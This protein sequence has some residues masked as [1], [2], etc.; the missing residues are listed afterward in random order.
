MGEGL[1]NHSMLPIATMDHGVIDWSTSGSLGTVCR[2]QKADSIA[3]QKFEVTLSHVHPMSR[4][5][6]A[7]VELTKLS[8]NSYK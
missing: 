4:Y 1:V 6:T 3:V 7:C 8:P 5:A 2:V